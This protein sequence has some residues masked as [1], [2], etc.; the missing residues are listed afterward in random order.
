MNW[1]VSTCGQWLFF[2]LLVFIVPPLMIGILRKCKAMMQNRIGASI[3]QPFF[4]LKKFW[5]KEELLSETASWVFRSTAIINCAIVLLLAMLIPWL[6]FKPDFPHADLVLVIYLL[7]A[8]RFFTVL[9][10]LDTGSAFGGFGASREVTLAMLVEPAIMLSLAS[11]GC[12]C[13]TSDL[14]TIF[15]YRALDQVP[16]VVWLLAGMALF[17]ASLIE[18]SRMPVDDP[19]TH[20]E[21][22]MV[23]EAMILENSGPNLAL[24]EFTHYL[25]MAI[26]WGLSGQCFLHAI[27]YFANA[28]QFVQAIA[29]FLVLLLVVLSVVLIEC[30]AVKL[31]WKKI[32]E[33]IAFAIAMSLLCVFVVIVKS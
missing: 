12:L 8:T 28:D 29:S 16:S 10:A 17:L 1:L 33:F 26:I 15:A 24:T 9:A 11:L 25:K 13:Q 19:T 21:L 23:H 4:D 5:S 27:P 31:Q 3:F 6:S 30:T 14:N 22:T 20:L 2:G 18:F 7:A 32:P